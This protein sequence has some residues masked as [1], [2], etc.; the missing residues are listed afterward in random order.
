M[1]IIRFNDNW[2]DCLSNKQGMEGNGYPFFCRFNQKEKKTLPPP[3]DQQWTC[4]WHCC[5]SGGGLI[6]VL[7][8]HITTKQVDFKWKCH[9]WRKHYH[10]IGK[11][12]KKEHC[13]FFWS[14]QRFIIDTQTDIPWS[15]G[16]ICVQNFDDSQV[17]QF[18]LR[19][20]SRCVLHRCGNQ[21]IRRLEL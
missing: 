16:A 17:L 8:H 3:L 4:T 9:S 5:S 7:H 15:H 12:Q 13:F 1:T 20:A 6:Y 21:A 11:E 18:T 14:F 19:I 10:Q 2:I